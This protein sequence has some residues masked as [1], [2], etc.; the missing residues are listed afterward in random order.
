MI[1]N[2]IFNQLKVLDKYDPAVNR[3]R[4][5]NLANQRHHS[6]VFRPTSGAIS[7]EQPLGYQQWL[8]SQGPQA[9]NIFP[10]SPQG[11]DYWQEGY[12]D[13]LR[14][15]NSKYNQNMSPGPMPPPVN[16][17]VYGGNVNI[18][19]APKPNVPNIGSGGP[20]NMRTPSMGNVLSGR[21]NTGPGRFNSPFNK[22]SY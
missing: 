13:Y 9:G 3:G 22:K 6:P 19:R 17:G 15:W 14:G 12:Q 1:N 8:R 4:N 18:P 7:S 2:D 21:G 11:G 20:R 16:P 5:R 10:N